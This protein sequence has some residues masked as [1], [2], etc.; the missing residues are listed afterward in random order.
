M[1]NEREKNIQKLIGVNKYQ[2]IKEVENK[3]KKMSNKVTQSQP[4][5][6]KLNNKFV[7]K[8]A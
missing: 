1:K 3:L 7:I 6:F 5:N 8:E 4:K 2:D